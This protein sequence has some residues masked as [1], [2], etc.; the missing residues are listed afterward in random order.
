MHAKDKQENNFSLKNFAI[1]VVKKVSPQNLRREE[2]PFIEKYRTYPFGLNRYKVEVFYSV[3]VSF[4]FSS[5][6]S[7]FYLLKIHKMQEEDLDCIATHHSIQ[8]VSNNK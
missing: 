3:S 1:A 4:Y 6:T 7:K 8:F 5:F 2:F